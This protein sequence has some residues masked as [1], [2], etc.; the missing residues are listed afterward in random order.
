M[1]AQRG[2]DFV[3]LILGAAKGF[4]V[5]QFHL[6]GHRELIGVEIVLGQEAR[7]RFAGKFGLHF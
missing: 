6:P 3:R 1:S 4:P 7:F 5:G 2:P